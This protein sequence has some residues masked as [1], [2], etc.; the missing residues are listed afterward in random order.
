MG[1]IPELV[2][3]GKTGELFEAGNV[4]DL[5]AAIRKITATP[6]T[7]AAYTANCAAAEFETSETYYEKLMEIYTKGRDA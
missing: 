5:M 7:L 2:D 3:P 1:G 4:D 6:E